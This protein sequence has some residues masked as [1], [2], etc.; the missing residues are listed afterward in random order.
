MTSGAA[1]AT[2]TPG[3]PGS[4]GERRTGAEP[5]PG[6]G[7]VGGG[8]AP[9]IGLR[10]LTEADFPLLGSWL[11]H[12][13]VARWWHHDPSPEAVERDFGPAVRGEEPSQELLALADGVPVGL[14]QR[15]RFVDYPE[16]RDE[17]A[18][19]VEVPEGAYTVDYLIGPPERVGRGLGPLVI[20]AAVAEL[21]RP[22][23]SAVCVIVPVVAGNRRS[24]RA[25]ERAGLR[26]VGSSPLEPDNPADDPLHHVYRIDRPAS[27]G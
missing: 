18:T 25:L 10:R 27:A 3:G 5:G 15:V 4:G 23:W 22:P 1:G 16:Y 11:A 13:H 9:V 6:R 14:V 26:R 19:V 8:D 17:L 2:G 7:A 12:P 21:W 20:A 24:W